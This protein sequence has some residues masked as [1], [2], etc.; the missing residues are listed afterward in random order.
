LSLL[1]AD[2]NK[3][4]L[5]LTLVYLII[6][7]RKTQSYRHSLLILLLNFL[8]LTVGR[9]FLDFTLLSRQEIYGFALFD[10]KY[11]GPMLLSDVFLLLIYQHYLSH[12]NNKKIILEH[13]WQ[14]ASLGLLAFFAVVLLR[15]LNHELGNFI[16]I[17]SL[18]ILRFMLLF[19][20]PAIYNWQN[21]KT[22]A[23][24]Y[25]SVASLTLFHSLM[26]WTEQLRSENLGR[27]IEHS[28]PGMSGG[29]RAAE[30]I[31]LLRADGLFNEPNIAAIFLL[32]NGLLLITIAT[33]NN[34]AQRPFLLIGLFAMLSIVFTGSRSLYLI[35]AIMTLGIAWQH[36][37]IALVW[38]QE[39]WRKQLLRLA[40]LL[41]IGISASYLLIRIDTLRNV[42]SSDGSWSYRRELHQHIMSFAWQNHLGI[43]LDLTPYY[44]AKTFKT[45]DNQF[46]VFDP[47]PAHNI[48]IQVLVE[49]GWLGA[50]A[51][52]FF[53]T[54]SLRA[55][56]RKRSVFA[57]SC[58]AYVVAAQLHPS[59]TN[60]YQLSAFFF[61]YLG[62]AFYDYHR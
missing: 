33:K 38:V 47:A 10:I 32:I 7:L 60:H 21:E 45:V 49:T 29:T 9:N 19:L 16:L 40:L 15:S 28:L 27:F 4:V 37:Q 6:L 44:L 35:S 50:A 24:F 57:T 41:I 5:G 23:V 52:L 48:F 54:Y 14:V 58:L 22:Q 51:F 1:L 31:N 2:S 39:L 12:G 55:A 53:L 30:S 3:I 20:L 11:F 59:F 46:T 36:R 34:T 62:L 26:I 42:F 8:P 56:F 18:L 61:L 43:G 25:N 13:S 17:G